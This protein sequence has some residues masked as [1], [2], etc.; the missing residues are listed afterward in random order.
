MAEVFGI[1][2]II[3]SQSIVGG[4]YG[5]A[6]SRGIPAILSEAGGV[7]QLE[8][9]DVATLQRGVRNVLRLLGVTPGAPEPVPQPTRLSRFVWLRSEHTGC[10]Y[11]SLRAGDRVTEGQPIGVIK[12]YWG[13]V[14]AEHKAP[15]SGVVIFIV[16]S[17]AINPT[18]PLIGIGAT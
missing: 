10:W 1:T 8:E 17:L 3:V 15:A 11:P 4:T 18:D 2:N 12:D 5:A 7:G 13:D 6:A 9:Q 14:L 16:T